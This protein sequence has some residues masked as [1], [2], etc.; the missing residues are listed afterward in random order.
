MSMYLVDSTDMTAIADAI[1]QKDGTQTTMTVSQ[2]PTRIQNIPTGG[3]TDYLAERITDTLTSYTIPNSVTG[4]SAYS[5]YNQPLTSMT[6]P[7]SL[8]V[9]GDYS[10]YYCQLTSLFIPKTVTNIGQYAFFGQ[11]NTHWDYL[12]TS[13][14]FDDNM[15]LTCS[16]QA[17][18][19][20]HNL[21]TLNNFKLENFPNRTLPNALFANSGL[22]GDISLGSS[23]TIGQRAFNNAYANGYLYI[24]LTQTDSSILTTSYSFGAGT[25]TTNRSFN[26]DH[27][28]LVVPVGML[29]DYQSAF[30]NYSSIMMEE[31]T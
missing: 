1:R 18:G 4:L 7:S 8:T 20:N 22:V 3:G 28:K 17:F 2:M 5:F 16:V 26:F 23:G 30:H 15:N 14:T 13:I 21:T 19:E 11:H 6:F 10:F 9:I 29:S 25:S 12:L 24:H 31:T 27:C